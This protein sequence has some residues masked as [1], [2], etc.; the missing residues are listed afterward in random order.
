[1]NLCIKR[2]YVLAFRP[3]CLAK[4]A[5]GPASPSFYLNEIDFHG[6]PV[7]IPST[8]FLL[9]SGLVGLAGLRRKFRKK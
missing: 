1:M 7:P 4:A 3:A 2:I 6:D 5:W 9:G 8:I